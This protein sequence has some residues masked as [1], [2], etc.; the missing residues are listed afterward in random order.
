M[1]LAAFRTDAHHLGLLRAS[2]RAVYYRANGATGVRFYRYVVLE[3]GQESSELA[4]R[5]VPYECRLLE[6]AEARA[7]SSDPANGMIPALVEQALRGGDHCYG[8]LDG[9]VLAS[10]GWY[11]SRPTRVQ[12]RLLVNFDSRYL[13]M[14][15]GYTRPEY[16]GQ[17]LHGIGLARALRALGAR[18]YGGI[19]SIAERMNFASLAS[20]HRTGFRDCGTVIVFPVGRRV[21]ILQTRAP[22]R[23]G[24]RLEPRDVD[25]DVMMG[26]PS[27]G[28]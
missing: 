3:L 28:T 2:A 19:V 10:S 4:T 11:S 16:R 5:A 25:S 26:A 18:G 24:L 21:L 8:I 17:N 14:H 22:S 12:E 7:F 6:H 27:E 23:Y 1:D 9:N 20:A 15:G 13:Y